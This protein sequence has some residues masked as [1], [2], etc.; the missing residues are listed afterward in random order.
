MFYCIT[1]ELLPVEKKK[2]QSYM[3]LMRRRNKGKLKEKMKKPPVFIGR[4]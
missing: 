1:H 3:E 4:G 2:A